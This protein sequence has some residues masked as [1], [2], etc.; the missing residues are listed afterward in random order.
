MQH[1]SVDF[2]RRRASVEN[3]GLGATAPRN[4]QMQRRSVAALTTD[5]AA[6]ATSDRTTAVQRRRCRAQ[7]PAPTQGS[8]QRPEAGAAEN[9]THDRGHEP[10]QFGA[11][12]G[13]GRAAADAPPTGGR[14]RPRRDNAGAARR[15]TAGDRTTARHE[16]GDGARRRRSA[17]TEKHAE[18]RQNAG[19]ARPAPA[20]GGRRTLGAG[21]GKLA[22]R[23]SPERRTAESVHKRRYPPSSLLR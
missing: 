9:R 18:R 7:K 16:R 21:R 14:T 5:R 19:E 2:F 11:A 20:S 3:G 10:A 6:D 12:P 15:K 22:T 13:G 4:H 23:R 8:A 1:F 17:R